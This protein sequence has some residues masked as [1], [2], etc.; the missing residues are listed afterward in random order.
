MY[1]FKKD[2]F[3]KYLKTIWYYL[4]VK[5]QH[6]SSE[7]DEKSWG[8]WGSNWYIDQP[9]RHTRFGWRRPPHDCTMLSHAV[10]RVKGVALWFLNLNHLASLPSSAQTGHQI[11]VNLP[12][13]MIFPAINLQELPRTCGFQAIFFSD[14]GPDVWGA[15]L[16]PR[17]SRHP[18]QPPL[19]PQRGHRCEAR[20][21]QNAPWPLLQRRSKGPC[22]PQRMVRWQSDSHV[23]NDAKMMQNKDMHSIKLSYRT[24]PTASR[25][26]LHQSFMF[27]IQ[28]QGIKHNIFLKNKLLYNL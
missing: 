9:K 7:R 14:S 11:Y 23:K 1:I 15:E 2:F 20:R 16:P 4:I 8:G 3:Q 27:Y 17:S 24:E 28:E 26:N 10:S 6:A 22:T 12:L 19:A 25:P 13:I 5:K 21:A 18:S